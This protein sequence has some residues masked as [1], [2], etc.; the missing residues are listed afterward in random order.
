MISTAARRTSSAAVPSRQTITSLIISFSQ[1]G[2]ALWASCCPASFRMHRR[3]DLSLTGV[4]FTNDAAVI[5]D[6]DALPRGAA[7]YFRTI[8]P[9]QDHFDDR[10][11]PSSATSDAR[12]F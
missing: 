4:N 5:V 11:P 6:C 7:D 10:F 1:P 3:T 8:S 2:G 12:T 9:Q